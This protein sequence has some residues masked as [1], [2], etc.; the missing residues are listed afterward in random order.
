MDA[1]AGTSTTQ[2][3]RH[4]PLSKAEKQIV[5]KVYDGLKKTHPTTEAVDRC[6]FLTGVSA[7]TVERI[8]RELKST[9]TLSAPKTRQRGRRSFH[10]SESQMSIIRRTV[11][12][13]FLENKLPTI[14]SVKVKLQE[15]DMIPQMGRETLRKVLHKLNFRYMKRCRKSILIDKEEIVS[16][17]RRYLRSIRNYRVSKRKIYY[18]DETWINAGHTVSKIWHDTTIRT[19]R[20]AFIEGLSTGLRAPSGK[21]QRLIVA[22]IGSD[23]GFLENNAL[24]FISKK[25]GDYHEDMDA[26]CFERWFENVLQH[27]EP[28]SVVVLDNAPYHSRL[29]E[30]I[31]TMSDKKAVLQHWLREKSIPYGEDMVKLELIGIIKQHRGTYRQHAVDTMARLH[32]ITILRLPPYHCELNPIELIWA[33]MKGYVARENV[34]YKI[35]DVQ[36]LLQASLDSINS[37][38]WKNAISHVIKVEDDMW[39]LDGMVDNVIEPVII[40]LGSNDSDSSAESME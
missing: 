25:T 19:P 6:S 38:D 3:R 7:T 22:H 27:L 11:H 18:L 23:T 40:Q 24:V 17:R 21:G 30:R 10:L 20:Q 8:V 28:N 34:T 35:S 26:V 2:S 14:K 32:G 5:W 1:A 4:K 31:P 16:W 12:T 13:F 9:E 39:R 33:Q 29:V 36:R 37:T 15:N